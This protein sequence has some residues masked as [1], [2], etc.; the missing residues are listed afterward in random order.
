[1]PRSEASKRTLDV[2]ALTVAVGTLL[3]ALALASIGS[4]E[5]GTPLTSTQMIGA[6]V[7]AL[8]FLVVL[9]GSVPFHEDLKRRGLPGSERRMWEVGWLVMAPLAIG[10][11]WFR[12]VRE[13]EHPRT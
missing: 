13:A 10:A 8:A 11:Y 3:G 2:A 1:M 9:A 5:P 6:V 12:Y 7:L 4:I